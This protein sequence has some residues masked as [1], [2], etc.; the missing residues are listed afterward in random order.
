MP[1]VL[2]E[3]PS[4]SCPDR[5]VEGEKVTRAAWKA[6]FYPADRWGNSPSEWDTSIMCPRCGTEGIDPESGQLDSA[7]EELGERCSECGVVSAEFKIGVVPG[8]AFAACPHCG[9]EYPEEGVA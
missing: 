5:V 6:L 8:R 3:C 1:S 2:V 9:G 4:P 7:E